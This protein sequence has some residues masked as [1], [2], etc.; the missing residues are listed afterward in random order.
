MIPRS[1]CLRVGLLSTPGPLFTDFDCPTST[2]LLVTQLLNRLALRPV[3]R[4]P[5]PP[6]VVVT[7]P[8]TVASADFCPSL[9]CDR[10]PRMRYDSFPL[11]LAAFTCGHFGPFRASLS[12]ASLPRASRL[13]TQFLSVKS[14]FC[15][16]ASSPRSLALAQLPSASGSSDQRPQE[17]F[18]P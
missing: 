5:C 6:R 4:F 18:T 11:T 17:T 10:S 1:M 14:R 3:V 12:S 13:L 16:P 7:P 9:R 8:T 15:S 2:L